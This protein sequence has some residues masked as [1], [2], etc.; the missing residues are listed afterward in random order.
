MPATSLH[1]ANDCRHAL[2]L[3]PHVRWVIAGDGDV[4]VACVSDDWYT[5]IEPDDGSRAEWVYETLPARQWEVE[6]ESVGGAVL[7]HFHAAALTGQ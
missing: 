3:L 5:I 4:Y 1:V 2:S 6:F 7:R